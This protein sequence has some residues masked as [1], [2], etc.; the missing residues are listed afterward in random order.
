MPYISTKVNVDL[1]A[2]KCQLLKQEYGQAI[3]LISGKSEARLMLSFEKCENMFFHG[4]G[5]MGIAMVEVNLFG[6]AKN[7]DCNNLTAELTKILNKH[8]GINPQEMF[9]KYISTTQWGNNGANF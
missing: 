5:D 1:S 4:Q 6:N 7:E 8:L 9:F 3:S 2:E